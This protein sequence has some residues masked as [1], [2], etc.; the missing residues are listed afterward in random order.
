LNS[1]EITLISTALGIFIAFMGAK[2]GAYVRGRFRSAFMT[3]LNMTSNFAGVPLAFAY[4]IILGT[5]GVIRQVAKY[6][7][8]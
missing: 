5:S 8:N 2:A 6:L 1:L 7:W 4:M 3:V